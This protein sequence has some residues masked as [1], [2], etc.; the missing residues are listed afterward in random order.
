MMFGGVYRG[1]R[2]LL[3]GHSGFKGSWLSAWLVGLGAEV[4]GVSLPPETE[5]NHFSLLGD[6]G[7]RSEWC[8]VRD[9]AKLDAIMQT[10]RPEI[11]FHLAAQPLVR[12]SYREP[13]ETFAVNV[14]GTVNLLEAAR[15]VD[16]L[17]AA[18]VVT[19][20][21]CYRNGERHAGYREEDPL[22]GR[23]P[24]S[25]SKGCQE[26]VAASYRDSFFAASGV[27][28]ATAR[29]G[30]VI[31]G[32]D[33]AADRLVP[34]LVRAAAKGEVEPLRSPDAVRPWQHVLE[35]LSGYLELGRRLL[36]GEKACADAWNFGPAEEQAVT[37][38][39]A[40]ELLRRFWP[41]VEFRFAPQPGAPHEAKLLRLDCAKA[42]RELNW[43]GVWSTEEAF[44]HTAGWYRDYY[45]TG[46]VD[47]AAD[48]AAYCSD[49]AR[50]GLSWTN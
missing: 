32:G 36:V 25:A 31:G 2:V 5:P 39:E 7:I 40:A 6:S 45:E 3:T 50:R 35:P 43:R 42:E 9:A 38:G 8:D 21:K 14:G 28:L 4:C 27:L 49:A 41:K 30:N 29:A 17:C 26:I 46:R 15:R 11:L 20:D 34:D 37:V 22:G 47:T 1:R 12:L 10:F 16:S 48:L 44:R 13:A 33:W 19:S 18:V 23:D 24:Y